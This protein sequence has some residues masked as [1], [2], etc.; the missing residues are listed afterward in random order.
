MKSIIINLLFLIIL[1]SYISA[2]DCLVDD[3]ALLQCGT[4]G[5]VTV[6]PVGTSQFCEN[7]VVEFENL[8]DPADNW[9]YFEIDFG[10]GTPVVTVNNYDNVSHTFNFSGLDKCEE[11][12]VFQNK[13]C[14]RGVRECAEGLTTNW[15]SGTYL[16]LLEPVARIESENIICIGDNV[17]IDNNSCNEDSYLW[18]F[19]N[20]MSSTDENPLLSFSTPGTYNV[21]L[22]VT[23][24]CGSDETIETITAV[25]FPTANII[26]E[27]NNGQGCNPSR[28]MI[29]IDA[30]EWVTDQ[31]SGYFEWSISP[32]YNNVNGPWCFTNNTQQQSPC[33]QD[34]TNNFC[35]CI[36]DSL[37]SNQIIDSLLQLPTLDIWFQEAGEYLV[38]LDYGNRCEDLSVEQT[39]TIYEPPSINNF[40]NQNACD[41]IELCYDDLDIDFD[42]DIAFYN[43]VFINGSIT[44][45]SD[46]N[47]DFGC[48]TFTT[49]GSIDLIL[50]AFDPCE[51]VTESIIVNVIETGVVT[52]M[53]PSPNTICQND[54]PIPL[55]P[56]PEGGN[57]SSNGSLADFIVN[58]TLFPSLADGGI[59]NIDYVLS[60]ECEAADQFSFTIIEA[61][62]IE[63]GE[64]TPA[65]ESITN[66]NPEVIAING[67]IDGYNW[68]LCDTSGVTI[69][70]STDPNPGFDY[71]VAGS[72]II[73]V[74]L[75][76][77]ECG[78]VFDTSQI[79]IQANEPVIIDPFDN[80][81]CPGIEPVI[82]S[83]NPPGGTWSGVGITDE[84]NGV[85]DPSLLTS[86]TANITYSLN[87]GVCSSSD[88]Q[89]I[90]VIL[91]NIIV[92][93]PTSICAYDGLYNLGT[94][95]PPGGIWTGDALND[96]ELGIVDITGFTSDSAY[97][98][99]YC[100]ESDQ[101]ECQSC[102]TTSITIEP[103]PI[104]SFSLI[105]SPCEGNQFSLMNESIGASNYQWF[106]GDGNTDNSANPNHTYD[107]QGDYTIQLIAST[108][109]GCS[110]TITQEVHVT[111]PPTI[112]NSVITQDG[113]AP[114]TVEYINNS[115]GEDIEQYWIIGATDTLFGTNP[116]IIL[117]GVQTDSL[118][119]VELIVEND[120]AEVRSIDFVLVHPTPIASFGINDDEGCSPDTVNF[121]NLTS[122]LPEIF[123]WDFGNGMTSTV[124]DPM[125]VVYTSPEDSISNYTITLVA[126]NMCGSDTL[127]QDIIVFPNNID[128]FFQI[129]TLSGCPP[130]AVNISSFATPGAT[131]TYDFGDGAT[132]DIADTTYIFNTPGEY[133]IT[134][135]ASQCGIDST[136]SDTIT[137]FPL[138]NVDFDLPSFACVGESV[139]LEN[140]ST[141]GTVTEW[142]FG[143]GN[144][145]MDF[146]AEHT[147]G[148]SGNYDVSLIVYS[149]FFNCPDTI[150]KSIV[151][152]ELPN[153]QFDISNSAPCPNE[154]VIFS[155]QGVGSLD[156]EWNFGDG[157]GGTQ[158]IETHSYSLPGLYEV[159]LKVYDEFGCS[160]DSTFINLIVHPNPSANWDYT[161][162]E[163]CQYHDTIEIVNLSNGSVSNIWNINGNEL[164]N[165]SPTIDFFSNEAGVSIVQLIVENSFGCQDSISDNIITLES[166]TS[167]PSFLDSM[168]CQPL[169]LSFEDISQNA[170][171]TTWI[172]DGSNSSSSTVANNIFFEAGNYSNSLIAGNTNGCPN[173]TAVINIE[174]FPKPISDFSIIPYDS[175]GVPKTIELLNQSQLST[176]YT[177]NFGEGS[178]STQFEPLHEYNTA[179]NYLISLIV[180]NEFDCQDTSDMSIS[181]FTQPI[182]EFS[183]PDFN[184]C[185]G[186]TIIFDNTSSGATHFS[187]LIN[188]D[189]TEYDFPI[190]LV[191]VGE[192]NLNI[193]AKFEEFCSDTFQLN[194][195]IIIHDKPFSGF[196]FIENK[197][198]D[199]IGGIN[200]FNNSSNYDDLFWEF[201]DG[202]S[203]IEENPFY[204]YDS[205]GPQNVCLTAYNYNDGIK[206]CEDKALDEI[207]YMDARTFF[208]PNAISPD[209]NFGEEE[210]GLFIPKGV[211]IERYE[212]N[213][214]SPW[215][216][217]IK[218]LNQVIHGE[219]ADN[220]D[221]TFKGQPVP[222]GAYIYSGVVSFGQGDNV[223]IHGTVTVIR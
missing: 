99:T 119:S 34:A 101:I 136:K 142:L 153:P 210:V 73:K 220:W 160:Q 58:D 26:A 121:M 3:T 197:D 212:L 138:A 134:Q 97:L 89:V 180:D 149:D 13:Y 164:A 199:I 15:S 65:C 139:T 36:P 48:V 208:V 32:S 78:S 53:D 223:P 2:Q 214:Y 158:Q 120:C 84:I 130:L 171:L 147:Y 104:A 204:E 23:N 162:S 221:G 178:S 216:E 219:P 181:L 206:T 75:I 46:S 126:A 200:F 50:E 63:L 175:C 87:A 72:Y 152:P 146:N 56:N 7:Q 151:V 16:V 205:D 156:Y 218:T 57:Y 157:S 125:S 179:D 22:T 169:Q 123:S 131:V 198:D 187:Y 14:F 112:D 213:I 192:Y 55:N 79:V 143:D 1:P 184:Y 77:N 154:A 25:D 108:N 215:G 76:S 24:A 106:F 9:D 83:A 47:P 159:K 44:N 132:G 51:N 173:D 98:F 111:A 174:V 38:N 145:S 183:I 137:V 122:G 185:E 100:V 155:S 61:P 43:W 176:G 45:Y 62:S 114:L 113:C 54:N 41:E 190:S 201:G 68:S 193:I 140:N 189:D 150:T 118:I 166:P 12:P 95:N 64:N 52:V 202:S 69:L 93:S 102:A 217:H 60:A 59:Y 40:N 37:L 17:N 19:G 128:A 74:E 42:G 90:E 117:D 66:F 31:P 80:P 105:G 209:N 141:G 170:N 168:G 110:D 10:D 88:M 11:G 195:T 191:D 29:T 28:Q 211:G 6:R 27:T 127:S 107:I 67:E 4:S 177:W 33:P 115:F 135:Y 124:F 8:S 39:I 5:F 207:T 94:A 91:N 86:S 172:F 196:S 21:T 133:V 194:G 116:N 165:N 109:F 82:L 188:G 85:F 35:P 18:E 129:D 71:D 203:S 167:I 92:P 81:Y 148:S 49:S 161:E 222:M 144:T 182:S 30:N 96:N 103:N 186:D 20:G 163:I 70:N